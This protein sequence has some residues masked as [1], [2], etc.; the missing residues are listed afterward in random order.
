MCVKSKED[1]YFYKKDCYYTIVDLSKK[2]N[3]LTETF[4]KQGILFPLHHVAYESFSW[5]LS[6]FT[7]SGET[8]TLVGSSQ[9]PIHA[10]ILTVISAILKR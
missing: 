9:L 10:A 8:C 2:Q 3:G 1:F 7:Q 6:T 4:R 5:G